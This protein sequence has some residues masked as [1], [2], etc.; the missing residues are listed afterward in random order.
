MNSATRTYSQSRMV[1]F[2]AIMATIVALISYIAMVST[3]V[4]AAATKEYYNKQALTKQAEI[5]DLEQ[6]YMAVS[7]SIDDST[8]ANSGLIA[9]KNRDLIKTTAVGYSNVSSV[10]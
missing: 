3:M 5:A 8:L 9:L 4:H 6:K 1:L 7:T 2:G 10:Q